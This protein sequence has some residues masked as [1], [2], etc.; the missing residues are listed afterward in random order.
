MVTATNSAIVNNSR[1]AEVDSGGTLTLDRTM[2]RS[3]S[4]K[5]ISN[6]GSIIS[7]GNN[8]IADPVSGNPI[9]PVALK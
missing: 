3:E 9:T 6:A 7:F 8:A 5:Y 1:S 4:A 2:V